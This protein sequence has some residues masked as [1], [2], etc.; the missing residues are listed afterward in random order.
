MRK[1]SRNT[2][3]F[4]AFGLVFWGTLLFTAP[5]CAQPGNVVVSAVS[6]EFANGLNAK[7]V[8]TVVARLGGE[9][10][11][12]YVS[13]ARKL[14]LMEQGRIDICAGL[15][16]NKERERYIRYVDPPY[17]KFSG[18]YFFIKKGSPVKL[19]T[20]DDL[21]GLK[22]ATSINSR[23]FDKFDSDPQII[24]APVSKVEQKFRML[25]KGRVDAVV[26]SYSGGMDMIQRLGLQD[27]IVVADFRYLVSNPIYIGVSRR[28][29]LMKRIDEIEEL[30]S[31][32][33]K[34]GEFARIVDE[35]YFSLESSLQ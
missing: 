34:D 7:I 25:A 6:Q 3:C 22:V 27:E 28:S 26:H 11:M 4:W 21:H 15:H 14:V 13:F 32:M 16:R 33:V 17:L 12:K 10:D 31:G 1:K 35:H 23:Y 8:K 9:L 5:L 30:V 19:E 20:Y 2:S 18:K 24:K 29:R